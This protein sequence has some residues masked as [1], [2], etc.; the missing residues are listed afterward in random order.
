[1]SK[2]FNSF[3]IRFLIILAILLFGTLIVQYWLNLNA[4][5]NN[6]Q[7][8]AEQAKALVAG[9]TLGMKS[10][11][12]KD[13]L[14]Q[15]RKKSTEPLPD[16]VQNILSI[17]ENWQV[18]DSLD[19][20]YLPVL[21][22][23]NIKYIK[24]KDIPDLPPAILP[25]DIAGDTHALPPSITVAR[26]LSVTSPR[27]FFVPFE[28]VTTSSNREVT[29]YLIVIIGP[30][31]QLSGG[32]LSRRA[33]QPLFYT[34]SVLLIATSIM[35]LLVWRF[36]KPI[37]DLSSAARKVASGKLNFLVATKRRDEMGQLVKQFNEMIAEL[38]RGRELEAKLSQAEKSAVVGRLA[39]G[40]AHEIRNPLNYINLTLD[41]LR[42]SYTPADET[43]QEKYQSHILN[44]KA[45]VK[46]IN[47]LVTDF[48][49]YT[50]PRE[51]EMEPIDL[52]EELEDSMRIVED[53]AADN[54]IKTEIRFNGNVPKI[55]GDRESLRS[56][57]TNLFINAVQAM[58]IKGGELIVSVNPQNENSN[59]VSIEIKDTG[60]GIPPEHLSKLFEPYFSTKE[61]GTGL[62]LA[63]VKKNLEEHKGTI[64][65]QSTPDEGTTFTV[66][67]PTKR[68]DEG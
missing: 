23:E 10:I 3:R 17:D 15:I 66:T 67:L 4:E 44:L 16:L 1:M 28:G 64:D 68:K 54:N 13:Y 9:I 62:G 2:I 57:F 6:A 48:L 27:A 30:A 60:C 18:H 20:R 63:T 22:G 35:A 12:S 59:N 61:T 14:Y 36:T 29:W 37:A 34:L 33:A 49:S 45:E 32:I 8:Q 50:R 46:R 40:I 39:S 47:K 19:T 42:T 26:S 25:I 24:L 51:L 56:V 31:D 38:K 7:R 53:Q 21:E 11:N 65:V 41:R 58:G 43:K 55:I 52:R 5:R